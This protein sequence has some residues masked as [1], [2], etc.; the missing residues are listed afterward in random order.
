[1]ESILVRNQTERM[2]Y[3]PLNKGEL[4]AV[5]GYYRAAELTEMA[6]GLPDIADY[7]RTGL[8]IRANDY[9]KNPEEIKIVNKEVMQ[10]LAEQKL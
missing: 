9:R 5:L 8:L 7:E 1:M 10:F 3:S 2:S 6:A 4:M